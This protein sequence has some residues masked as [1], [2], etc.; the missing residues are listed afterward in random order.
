MTY[1]YGPVGIPP[2][3]FKRDLEMTDPAKYQR[4]E[5][6]LRDKLNREDRFALELGTRDHGHEWSEAR[7]GRITA[8]MFQRVSNMQPTTPCDSLLEELMYYDKPDLTAMWNKKEHAIAEYERQTGRSDGQ[9]RYPVGLVAHPQLGFVAA[10]PDGIV[11]N[12]LILKAVCP[13]GNTL[14]RNVAC[15]DGD[16]KLRRGHEYY[17]QVQVQMAC[18]GARYCDFFVWTPRKT[19]RDRIEFDPDFWEQK[20]GKVHEFYMECV[21]PELVDPRKARGLPFRERQ[22]YSPRQQ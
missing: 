10:T 1:W 9:V 11:S 14:L 4:G 6:W 17:S 2:C 13:E 5:A 22:C 12:E 16:L 7:R 8:R 15:L 19:A 3:V 21:L 20:I 18:C